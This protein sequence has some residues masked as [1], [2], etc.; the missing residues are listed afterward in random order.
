MV[1]HPEEML[2]VPWPRA[3]VWLVR[4]CGIAQRHDSK[5][6]ASVSLLFLLS[7]ESELRPGSLDTGEHRIAFDPFA[8]PY[9]RPWRERG[10]RAGRRLAHLQVSLHQTGLSFA[11]VSL[12]VSSSIKFKL[13]TVQRAVPISHAGAR[14]GQC[15]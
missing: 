15:G 13:L 5:Y 4:N 11:T 6:I 10:C 7:P 14:P 3:T 2:F 12:S 1:Q 8:F 9:D